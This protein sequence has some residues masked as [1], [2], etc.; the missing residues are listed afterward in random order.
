MVVE[1]AMFGVV[2][3]KQNLLKIDLLEPDEDLVKNS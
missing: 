1:T 2:A 3:G